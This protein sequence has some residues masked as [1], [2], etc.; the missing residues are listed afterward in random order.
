MQWLSDILWLLIHTPPSHLLPSLPSPPL[1]T[2]TLIGYCVSSLQG[3]SSGCYNN[4][5]EQGRPLHS[6]WTSLLLRIKTCENNCIKFHLTS[7]Y[8]M[9]C[10]YPSP[11]H[12]KWNLTQTQHHLAIGQLT[13]WVDLED[14][15]VVQSHFGKFLS[16]RSVFEMLPI[17][18]T[19]TRY[20]VQSLLFLDY[21]YS[22]VILVSG[23]VWVSG[24]EECCFLFLLFQETVIQ[25]GDYIRL[26]IVGTR[27]DANDIVSR[28][29]PLH[30]CLATWWV[31]HTILLCCSLL[32][33]L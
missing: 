26:R 10:L 33:V 2:H 12:L 18:F 20:T 22:C 15:V 14:K 16:C 11:F 30:N 23:L 24:C 29:M 5:G 21:L 9:I 32:L 17:K 8:G 31:I 7:I 1:T 27:V 4:S 28:N 6:D 13:L 19:T 25:E 3:G